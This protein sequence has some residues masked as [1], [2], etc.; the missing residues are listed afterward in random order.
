MAKITHFKFTIA[1]I[2]Y[3]ININCNSSG[4]FTGNLP[5]KVAS[6]LNLDKRIIGKTLDDIKV[7]FYNEMDR[8]KNAETVEDLFILIRYGAR[9]Q[10]MRKE[11]KE[12]GTLFGQHGSGYYLDLG[13]GFDTVSALAFDFQVCIRE[14]I[15]GEENWFK[16][17]KGKDFAHWDKEQQSNPDKWYKGGEFHYYNNSWKSIPFTEKAYI[18]LKIGR[19]SLRKI[20]EMLFNFIEQDELQIEASLIAG[21]LLEP[22]KSNH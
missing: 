7:K 19:E 18:T 11:K 10:Y 14:T 2:D 20:S 3:K 6:A 1:G 12:E 22:H 4:Q 13:F 16:A 9:G 5:D 15:D 17:K 8:Y 21:R